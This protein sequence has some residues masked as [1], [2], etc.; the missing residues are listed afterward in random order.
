M[1]NNNSFKYI[2]DNNNNNNYCIVLSS[3]KKVWKN[4]PDSL[5]IKDVMVHVIFSKHTFKR[6][7]IEI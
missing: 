2:V 4:S 1:I 3:L 5:I 6:I 7:F